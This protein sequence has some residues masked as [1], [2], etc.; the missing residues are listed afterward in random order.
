LTSRPNGGT[1][2]TGPGKS[3][4]RPAP[5]PYPQESHGPY[6]AFMRFGIVDTPVIPSA[7]T[8][9]VGVAVPAWTGPGEQGWYRSEF[10]C[11]S[12]SSFESMSG[13]MPPDQWGMSTAGAKNRN[14]NAS[15]VID[16]FFGPAAV[17]PGMAQSGEA[18]FKRQ[19]YQSM[20]GQL[21]SLERAVASRLP[22]V[23]VWLR[24]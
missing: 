9:D 23:A 3:T 16:A 8:S 7:T 14:W 19:L 4:P 20:I 2:K 5:F 10:G 17:F 6:T 12:W 13:Q 21:V 24:L 1:L 22:S 11:V 15:N 18:S